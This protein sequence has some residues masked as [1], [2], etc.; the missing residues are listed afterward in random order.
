MSKR[1]QKLLTVCFYEIFYHNFSLVKLGNLEDLMLF[2]NWNLKL[3][4]GRR[5]PNSSPPTWGKKYSYSFSR[6]IWN[7]FAR[8][9]F[10]KR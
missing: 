9:S 4:I 1:R 10:L 7:L 8:V 5:T 6:S 2:S 3:K